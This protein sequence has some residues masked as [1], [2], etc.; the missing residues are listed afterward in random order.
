[1]AL[2]ISTLGRKKQ[3]DPCAHLLASLAYMG[4]L[5]AARHFVAV[6]KM[7]SA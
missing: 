6:N 5:Q 4:T 7:D 2:K 3:A 1:M